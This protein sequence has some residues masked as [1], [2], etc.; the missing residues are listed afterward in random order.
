[1]I[2]RS[3]KPRTL[4]LI[5][6]TLFSQAILARAAKKM[7]GDVLNNGVSY[8]TG[9]L[10]NWTLVGVVKALLREIQQ[11]GSMPFLLHWFIRSS[12]VSLQ[13]IRYHPS[14]SVADTL[15]IVVLPP[16]G[17]NTLRSGRSATPLG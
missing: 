8:F 5:S 7:D 2:F 9:P 11:K 4:L 1:M 13:C 10:L 17:S 15:A 16:P 6:A 3:T 14:G 12:F